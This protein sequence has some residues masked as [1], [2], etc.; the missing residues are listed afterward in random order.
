M[1]SYRDHIQKV[2]AGN[3]NTFGEIM[4]M[5]KDMAMALATAQLHDRSLAE[6]AVQEA[7]LAAFIKLPMLQDHDAFP[8]WFRTI[9]LRHCKRIRTRQEGLLPFS[10]EAADI[11]AG[12]G[13]D[14]FHLYTCHLDQLMIRRILA[15]LPGVAREACIL[16]FVHG[17]SYKDI[18]NQLQLP[19]GTI[20][21]RI[22]DARNRIIAEFGAR[23]GRSVRLGYLPIS[24]HLLGMVT[25]HRH[26][27]ATY[28]LHLSK[29]LSW[30]RLVKALTGGL[31]EAAFIM[32]PLAMCLHNQGLPIRYVLDGHHDGSA[33]T[34]R[35]GVATRHIGMGST[36]AL[37]HS[38]STHSLLLRA[39]LGGD[40][41]SDKQ[42]TS[43][44]TTRF[45]SPSYVIGSLARHEIDG[46]FC[47]EP[48]NTT[49]VAQGEGRILARSGDLSPGHV[50]CVVV[51]TEHFMRNQPDLLRQ[52]LA[53]LE[54]ARAYIRLNSAGAA[55]IQA[56]YT[57]V[58]RDIAEH[59]LNKGY[60]TFSDLTPDRGRAE[61]VM[62][63]ALAA[64]ALKRPCNLDAF[65]AY[66]SLQK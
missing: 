42:G 60:I 64:G 52:F 45:I 54:D 58:D 43:D 6:D 51:I 50:C 7:F 21:R 15:A 48:W 31:L 25:H 3:K 30:G 5:F 41:P 29:F 24:D 10:V 27:K 66:D 40:S 20:K 26:D 57:G 17:H 22:H 61:Q 13:T 33:V 62:G 55:D 38:I 16:R 53:D 65:M 39:L 44:L 49:S 14:P 23:N 28:D 36:M 37:P 63:L 32:A 12:D 56:R 11:P 19:K 2:L 47:S 4:L 35:K 18:T 9:L 8:G 46:F 34:V 1:D 59:I